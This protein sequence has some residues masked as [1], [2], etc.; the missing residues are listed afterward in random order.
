MAPLFL[1]LS[2]SSQALARFGSLN[3]SRKCMG[4]ESIRPSS[5][6]CVHTPSPRTR[7]GVLFLFAILVLVGG[8]CREESAPRPQPATYE[9]DDLLPEREANSGTSDR[10]NPTQEPGT[11]STEPLIT[12]RKLNWPIA[13]SLSA[14]E[15]KLEELW[16]H[17]IVIVP[18]IDPPKTSSF[19]SMGRYPINDPTTLDE[20]LTDWLK[21][22]TPFRTPSEYKAVVIGGKTSGLQWDGPSP[23]L[24][25]R[26]KGHVYAMGPAGGFGTPDSDQ[27]LLEELRDSI[28]L[29]EDER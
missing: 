14:D 9:A 10:R 16:T 29:L 1:V 27:Q 5:H 21:R 18:L 11:P 24:L 2:L 19:F 25:F 8:G 26:Y 22:T 23:D 12:L 4:K 17:S 20:F 6:G 7:V 15:W 28:M 13:F 3:Y